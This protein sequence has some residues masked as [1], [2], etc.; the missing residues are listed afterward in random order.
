MSPPRVITLGCRLNAFESEVMRQRAVAAGLDDTIIVN[1]CAVT[2]EAGRQARQAIRR[3]RRRNPGAR[4]V[5]TGCAAQVDPGRFAAMPEVDR[6]LG[7]AGKLDARNLGRDDGERVAVTDI[8]T[9]RDTAGHLAGGFEGRARAFVQ[10]QQGCDHRCA[11]CIV[12]FARGRNRGVAP[13]RVVAQVRELTDNGYAEVVLTGV[14]VCS[15]GA[16]LAG[17]PSLGRLA[18]RILREVPEL[19]R[20]RL[21]TLDPGAPDEELLEVL[22]D[23]PRLL[24]HFHLSLQ[25]G[26]DVVLERMKRRHSRASAAELC[27]RLREARPDIVLGADLIAGFPTESDEMFARTLD[28][29]DDLGLTYLHVFPYSPRP[30]TPAARMPQVP[31]R[32]RRERAAILRQAGEKALRRYLEGRVGT[33]ARVLVEDKGRGHCEHFAPVRLAAGGVPGTVQD[34]VITGVEDNRLVAEPAP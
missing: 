34:T 7:N 29:V 24:P 32:L 19:G 4:I 3:A 18:G 11:F 9:V 30:G 22:A 2:A 25:S 27:R 15:Y 21:T 6:V 26:D 13:E 17:R 8:M 28:A 5:V 23:Q 20:L 1:T 14:D 33:A 16:D 31:V 10:V 12:P